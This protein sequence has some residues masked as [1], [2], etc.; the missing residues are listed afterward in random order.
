[1]VLVDARAVEDLRRGEVE[2]AAGRAADEEAG[3]AA[4]AIDRLHQVILARRQAVDEGQREGLARVDREGRTH[5]FQRTGDGIDAALAILLRPAGADV[6]AMERHGVDRHGGEE[7]GREHLDGDRRPRLPGRPIEAA[8]ADVAELAG[9]GHG[10]DRHGAGDLFQRARRGVEIDVGRD[11]GERQGGRT[12]AEG[13]GR[14]VDAG[15]AGVALEHTDLADRGHRGR[16]VRHGFDHLRGHLHHDV[17]LAFAR[18]HVCCP[19]V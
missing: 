6:L 12:A 16:H 15:E 3:I 17:F 4:G 9:G 5:R 14:G 13:E 7:V 19:F 11:E 10:D 2:L 18:E 1:M 8:A